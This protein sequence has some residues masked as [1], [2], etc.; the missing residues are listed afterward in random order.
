MGTFLDEESVRQLKQLANKVN[1][2][3]VRGP[4]VTF[5]NGPAT[6]S[7]CIDPP[8]Q[9][10]SAA[11]PSLPMVV[12]LITGDCAGNGKYNG[13]ILTSLA[14]EN[15]DS[16]VD[17]SAADMGTPPLDDNCIVA[18]LAEIGGAGHNLTEHFTVQYLFGSINGNDSVTGRPIVWVW[19]PGIGCAG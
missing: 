14:A 12:V 19:C 7:L 9:R 16:T 5:I 18:N 11:Q 10:N 15:F 3:H 1:S 6:M 4:G 8:R 13:K 17:L 2:F